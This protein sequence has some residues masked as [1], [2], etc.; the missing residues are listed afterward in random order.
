MLSGRTPWGS[1]AA[2]TLRSSIITKQ[3]APSSSGRT[4]IAAASSPPVTAISAASIVVTRS[5]SV[6]A[7]PGV[8]TRR[9]SSW[10]FTRFPLW[11]RERECAPSVL[12]TG[13]ALSHVVEPVVE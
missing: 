9:A 5:E 7:P 4:R 11:P 10:V 6:V 8:P 1:R 3:N 2:Y 12:N 13:C